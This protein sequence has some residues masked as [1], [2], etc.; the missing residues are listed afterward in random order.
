MTVSPTVKRFGYKVDVTLTTVGL[1]NVLSTMNDT[2]AIAH[3]NSF[4]GLQENENV[5]LWAKEKIFCG[6]P[7]KFYNKHL[8]GLLI[9]N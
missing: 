7:L 2:F 9:T 6:C 1:T 3:R 4:A 8:F 5:K